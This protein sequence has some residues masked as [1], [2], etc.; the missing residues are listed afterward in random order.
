MVVWALFS[1]EIYGTDVEEGDL[2]ETFE[3]VKNDFESLPTILST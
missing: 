2:I 1:L 3:V